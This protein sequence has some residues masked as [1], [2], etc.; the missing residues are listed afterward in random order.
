MSL[1]GKQEYP[2]E[3]GDNPETAKKSVLGK[4]YVASQSLIIPSKRTLN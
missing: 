2:T 4:L 1:M 3:S